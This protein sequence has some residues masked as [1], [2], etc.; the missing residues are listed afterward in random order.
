MMV[1]NSKVFRVL[2]IQTWVEW[3][4]FNPSRSF[5]HDPRTGLHPKMTRSSSGPH[6]WSK[7]AEHAR[8]VGT[9][10]VNEFPSALDPEGKKMLRESLHQFDK[11]AGIE[12]NLVV[13]P[14]ISIT[15]AQKEKGLSD[16]HHLLESAAQQ[17]AEVLQRSLGLVEVGGSRPLA[18]SRSVSL[19]FRSGGLVVHR[20]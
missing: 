9:V 18:Q 11:A 13:T 20:R 1:M 17:V 10:L 14:P 15:P 4:I 5:G 16:A 7:V 8:S 6:T 2:F 12:Y 3:L 19:T